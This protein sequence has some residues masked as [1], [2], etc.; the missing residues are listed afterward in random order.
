MNDPARSGTTFAAGEA[1]GP[2]RIVGLLGAGGMG[3]VF[4]ARD[5][6]LGHVRER[7]SLDTSR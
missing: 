4:R 5:T 2:Y 1:V 3:E 6:K 7:L